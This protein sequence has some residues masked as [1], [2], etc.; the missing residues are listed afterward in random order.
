MKHKRTFDVIM[1]D[2]ELK[3]MVE[4]FPEVIEILCK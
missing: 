4:E 2:R 1:N 3:T